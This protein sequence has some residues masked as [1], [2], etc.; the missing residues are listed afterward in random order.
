MLKVWVCA[1][2]MG[3][4]LGPEF[5]TQGSFLGRFS[6]ETHRQILKMCIFQPK[7]I[8]RVGTKASFGNL[9]DSTFRKSGGRS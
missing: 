8:I 3:A 6:S 4:F 5:S 9:A 2:H 7:F 1:T